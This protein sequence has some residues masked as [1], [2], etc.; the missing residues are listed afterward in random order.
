MG[1][2]A[3]TISVTAAAYYPWPETVVESEMVGKPLFEQFDAS[4]VRSISIVQYDT[5][6]NGLDRIELRRSG[7]KWIIPARKNYIATNANQISLAVNSLNGNVLEN[8]SSDQQDHVEYGVIDPLEFESTTNRAS[9]GTKIVLEDRNKRELA[10]L[11]VGSSLRNESQQNQMKHFVRIPGQPH[12]Y[13]MEINPAALATDFT[14]WVSPNL[15]QLSK[16]LPIDSILIKNYRI[17]PTNVATGDKAWNYLATMDVVNRKTELKVPVEDTGDLE[18]IEPTRENL[19]QLNG[20]GEFIGNIRFTDVQ[21]KSVATATAIKKRSSNDDSVFEDLK[22]FGFSVVQTDAE[23]ETEPKTRSANSIHNF[24][25]IGGEVV[26]RTSDGVSISVLIGSLAE[27]PSLGNLSLNHH[28]ML[29]AG[30]D[31]SILPVPK[32]PKK[33][34]E[35][36]SQSQQKAYLRKLEERKSKLKTAVQRAGELNQVYAD[37]YYIVS[38]E[39]IAGLR[40]ELEI[41]KSTSTSE[42]E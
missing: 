20:L 2:L 31:Q 34:D 9:L 12:V 35:E 1:L 27:S 23:P 37:W 21:K 39:I 32:S 25:A 13:V 36:L 24:N 42:G 18:T 40:P 17:D 11:I 10:S 8:R 41:E 3:I 15:L 7:E 33:D 22:P 28:I 30:V 5:D 38:E 14:R 16:D 4:S 26:V 29:V 19:L 6:R